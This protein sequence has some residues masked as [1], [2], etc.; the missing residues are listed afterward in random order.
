MTARPVIPDDH[1]KHKMLLFERTLSDFSVLLTC[2][3]NTLYVCNVLGGGN[4]KIDV[5]SLAVVYS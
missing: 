5:G 1:R 2:Y 4:Y 3:I